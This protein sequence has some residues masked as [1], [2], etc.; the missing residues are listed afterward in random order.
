[1]SVRMR[2]EVAIVVGGRVV[3]NACLLLSR[4]R[5]DGEGA[6]LPVHD[7]P[8]PVPRARAGG[9]V[10]GRGGGTAGVGLVRS[11]HNVRLVSPC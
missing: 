9:G 3:H 6:F 7:P 11:S 1:M 4:K 8:P 10:G 2:A 5:R